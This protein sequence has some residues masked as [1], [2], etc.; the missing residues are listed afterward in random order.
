MPIFWMPGN[1]FTSRL[2]ANSVLY[3]TT[4]ACK[5]FKTKPSAELTLTSRHVNETSPAHSSCTS[6]FTLRLPINYRIDCKM[7]TLVFKYGQ[8]AG[9][10]T[11]FLQLTKTCQSDIYFRHFH[12]FKMSGNT[13]SCSQAAPESC[14]NRRAAPLVRL[15]GTM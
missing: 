7:A 10:P 4:A 15:F 2:Y 6:E 3:D 13:R 1:K 8:Q 12:L 5:Y 14:N 11:Y 9:R